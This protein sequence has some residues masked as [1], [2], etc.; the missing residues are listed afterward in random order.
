MPRQLEAIVRISESLS[1]HD[2]LRT[3]SVVRSSEDG[4]PGGSGRKS[5]RRGLEALYGGPTKLI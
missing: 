5:C 4:A 2:L 1:V 3:V